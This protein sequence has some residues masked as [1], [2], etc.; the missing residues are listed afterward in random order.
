MRIITSPILDVLKCFAGM[1]F[2]QQSPKLVSLTR[3]T[4][5]SGKVLSPVPNVSRS[6]TTVVERD[7]GHDME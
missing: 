1:Q 6:S 2:P 7:S 5:T 3:E 4:R